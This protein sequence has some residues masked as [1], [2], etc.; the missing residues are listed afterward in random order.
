MLGSYV[1]A[2]VSSEDEENN[3]SL[4]SSLNTGLELGIESNDEEDDLNLN[5]WSGLLLDTMYNVHER[6]DSIIEL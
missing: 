3:S 1:H 2:D 4:G 6:D 5:L